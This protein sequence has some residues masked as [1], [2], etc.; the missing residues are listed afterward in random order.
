VHES[1]EAYHKQLNLSYNAIRTHNHPYR[2][3]IPHPNE[4]ELIMNLYELLEKLITNAN[5]TQ[6]W[7]D[8][9]CFETTENLVFLIEGLYQDEKDE[10]IQII[11]SQ[12]TRK[13]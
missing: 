9:K 12:Q 4:K 6:S 1:R 3:A 7:P 8:S 2:R 10:L 11:I 13:N 5:I